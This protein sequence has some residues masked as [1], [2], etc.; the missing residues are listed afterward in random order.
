LGQHEGSTMSITVGSV[1]RAQNDRI[2]F[3]G[4][5]LACALAVL[6]GFSPSYF[7]RGAELPTLRPLYQLHGALFTSWMLLLA[8]QTSLVAGRGT[9]IHRRL[10]IFGGVRA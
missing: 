10:G 2:F 4:M 8:V 5:A 9:H 6:I 1:A 7:M 3:T